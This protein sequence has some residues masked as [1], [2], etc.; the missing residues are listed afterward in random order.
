MP[1]KPDVPCANCGALLWSSTSS[2]PPGQRM[3]RPCRQ[4]RA[5]AA[6][7][8]VCTAC[9]R[10]FAALRYPG[11]TARRRVCSEACRKNRQA[12]S[13]RRLNRHREGSL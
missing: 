5:L 7:E 13:V 4:A 6:I 11:T 9:G 10:P 2:L 8:R 1:S 3:C 12:A